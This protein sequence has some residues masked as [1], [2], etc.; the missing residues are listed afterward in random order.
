VNV[1]DQ[2]NGAYELSYTPTKV[3]DY[4]F[5]V[6]LDGGLIGGKS[7]PFPLRVI[8]AA[9]KGANSI[10]YGPGI[11]GGAVGGP[12]NF[13]VETRDAFDNKLTKGGSDVA[14]QLVHQETGETV[15]VT[16]KDNG[17][18]TYECNYAGVAKAG[19][20]LL[21]SLS[22]LSVTTLSL[23]LL[24]VSL[25]RMLPSMFTSLLVASTSTIPLSSGLTRT[26]LVAAVPA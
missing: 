19:Y 9:A 14:G 23:L 6:T 24:V 16:V 26:R 8:P 18:G 15:P 4:K 11:E 1:N 22:S 7:N 13:T 17:D 12:N 25:L 5:A 10:A 21:P 20:S 3:G 2:N